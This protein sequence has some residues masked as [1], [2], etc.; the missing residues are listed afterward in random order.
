MQPVQ[1]TAAQHKPTTS[2]A[3]A[4]RVKTAD[5]TETADQDVIGYIGDAV[6]GETLAS[7]NVLPQ[8]IEYALYMFIIMP[9]NTAHE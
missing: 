6:I 7:R 9:R 1:A 4:A 8:I 2:A 5:V 3:P